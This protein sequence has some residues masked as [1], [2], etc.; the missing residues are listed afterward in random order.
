MTSLDDADLAVGSIW[1]TAPRLEE[2]RVEVDPSERRLPVRW[3]GI[4]A[5]DRPVGTHGGVGEQVAAGEDHRQE[6]SSDEPEPDAISRGWVVPP[7][8]TRVDAIFVLAGTALGI[9]RVERVT[10]PVWLNLDDLV[11][12][13][14][15]GDPVDGL[16]EVEITMED[17]RAIGA[18]WTED[19]CGAVV[20]ALRSTAGRPTATPGSPADTG[21][22]PPAPTP[23]A[24]DP[25]AGPPAAT[26]PVAAPPSTSETPSEDASPEAPPASPFARP[27]TATSSEPPSAAPPS[28]S[29]FATPAEATPDPVGSSP[30]AA[31]PVDAVPTAPR[32]PAD[33]TAA[34]VEAPT[35]PPPVT[36]PA[37][38][39]PLFAEEL[40]A[41][42]PLHAQDP[43]PAPPPAPVP[44]AAPTSAQEPGPTVGGAPAASL[45]LE[46]VV[47]LGGYPG[48]SKKRKKCVVGMSRTGLDLNGPGGL[49][50]R[51]GWDDVRSIEVQNSDEARFRMNT[52]IHRDASAL[53]V[54]CGQG[55]TI[56]LEARDCPT[57]ALRSAIT[58]LLAGLPVLVV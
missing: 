45:E 27:A 39:S 17:Q 5:S 52:K 6:I 58:Q 37:G 46:D 1:S 38:S 56:L 21:A 15:I 24:A 29:P 47:Y 51:V 22:H 57:I 36:A 40:P 26:A 41:S 14:A 28:S 9:G 19:F 49:N 3:N 44:S 35:A 50:F 23:L 11:N 25:F 16:L 54:E 20:E 30:F 13:D 33:V 2:D 12:L 43:M 7:G 42:A 48:Q 32:S 8:G 34:P 55:V 53:V 18:G 4:E 31:S 10:P